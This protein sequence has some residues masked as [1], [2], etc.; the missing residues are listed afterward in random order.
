[1]AKTITMMHQRSTEQR[2][3]VDQ[4]RRLRNFKMLV[5]HSMSAVLLND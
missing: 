5:S 4:R 1:M 3:A 2:S